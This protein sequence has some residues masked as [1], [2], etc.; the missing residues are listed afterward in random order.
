MSKIDYCFAIRYFNEEHFNHCYSFLTKFNRPTYILKGTRSDEYLEDIVTLPH[1]YV[2]SVD[3]DAFLFNTDGFLELMQFIAT[4]DIDVC[5]MRDG[6]AV[7]RGGHPLVINP[8]FLVL[9][10]KKI[11]LFFDKKLISNNTDLSKFDT[12]L[13]PEIIKTFNGNNYNLRS[14]EEP[15]Y[16]FFFYLLDINVKFHYLD[17]FVW[18]NDPGV[19]WDG[20]L[21]KIATMLKTNNNASF[22]LH[23]WLSSYLNPE[24][25]EPRFVFLS[26]QSKALETGKSFFSKNRL[27][28]YIHRKLFVKH[29]IK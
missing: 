6:G 27:Y 7:P 1:D 8:F 29:F 22:L 4:N 20:E 21:V 13:T 15:Y 26:H 28:Q 16:H 3:E 2:V 18:N 9:N 14:I 17:Y 23:C 12:L 25:R 10:T 11:R 24:T 5:G 19:I